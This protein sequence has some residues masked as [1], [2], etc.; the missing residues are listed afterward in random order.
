MSQKGRMENIMKIWV[1][2]RK[3][4]IIIALT[5]LLLFSG[6]YIGKTAVTETSAG[7]RDLPI[8][9]VDKQEKVCAISFDAAWGNEDTHQLI[10]ILDRYNVKTTFFLFC[11]QKPKEQERIQPKQ[12]KTKYLERQYR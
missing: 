12:G 8:Y 10:E 7:K 3:Q 11:C 9:C 2:G 5:I 4:G 6:I 1:I